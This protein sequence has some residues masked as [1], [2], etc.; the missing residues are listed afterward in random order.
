MNGTSNTGLFTSVGDFFSDLGN[1]G[2]GLWQKYT[3]IDL[4][5]EAVEVKRQQAISERY[6]PVAAPV[7][8]TSTTGLGGMTGFQTISIGLA[9]IGVVIAFISMRK[10]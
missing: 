2:L 8:A 10:R 5:D 3:E 4:L 1:A 7:G 6:Q 9:L